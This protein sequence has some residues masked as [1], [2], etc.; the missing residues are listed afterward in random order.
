MV[1]DI[2]DGNVLAYVGNTREAK[3]DRHSDAVDI[4]TARRSTGSILKPFLY[5]AMLDEGKILTRSLLPDVP[6]I[7]NGFAPRNFSKEYDGAVPADEALTRSLNIPAV[8]LLR[9]YRYEK[10]HSLLTGLG[11]TTLT[12]PP[13]HYGLSIILGG[14][15][16]SLWDI[17]GMYASM[18]RTLLN[19]SEHP[20]SNRYSRGDFHPAN[21]IART[22]PVEPAELEA[23]SWLSAAAI[24][25]TFD[26][27]TE[28]HRPGEESGWKYFTSSRKV[29]WKTG[30]SFGLRDGWAVG[31]TPDYTIG[32]WVGNA[33]GEGRPGLTGTD[34][35]A[36]MM[37]DLFSAMDGRSW[38][39]RPVVEMTEITV[40]TKSGQRNAPQCPET[41]RAWVV[42]AGLQSPP[43]PYHKRIH[44]ASNA[45]LRVNADCEPLS[46]AREVTW[47]VLP[48]AQEHFFRS[49]NMS[50]Q[51]LPPYRKDCETQSSLTAMDVLY[52]KP[53]ARM[54]IPRNLDGTPGEAVFELAHRNPAMN[55]HW[56]LDGKYIA[57]TTRRH[58]LPLNPES[59]K[60]VLVLVDD[61][62]ESIE[63]HF[64]VIP[65]L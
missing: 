30:T 9:S 62:G 5:A 33:D 64:E 22:A 58:F 24:Y 16:G 40:C 46:R 4:V 23:T 32:V 26:V 13:D 47:F 12:N 8:Q 61:S 20:G 42:K 59:G 41:T 44:L 18:A 27:L 50:Y 7:I 53:N 65:R 2:P 35:A 57:T 11:M 14:A 15:E 52:P 48:P 3:H 55:V 17:T 54:L 1:L 45:N 49:R 6:T 63:Q 25:Q 51:P 29:A 37:F 21:F 43:C 10:F 36:P 31:V 39:A 28:V 19:F 34:A 60:H 38:F 56:H